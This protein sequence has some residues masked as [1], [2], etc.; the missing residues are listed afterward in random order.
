MEIKK[1]TVIKVKNSFDCIIS[2]LVTVEE[3]ISEIE[4]LLIDSSE[5]QWEQRLK[6]T[7]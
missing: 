4:D 1:N 3:R 5:K 6:E 2:R 7:E